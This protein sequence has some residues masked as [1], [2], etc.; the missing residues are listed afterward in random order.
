M[1][2][3]INWKEDEDAV[4]RYYCN[5]G[6]SAKAITDKLNAFIGGDDPRSE[7]AVR[8][9]LDR[10]GLKTLRAEKFK[11]SKITPE[12]R[13]FVYVNRH[14]TLEQIRELFNRFF[15]TSF[16][17]TFI[18]K[19]MLE[20]RATRE[21]VMTASDFALEWRDLQERIAPNG[22]VRRHH[23]LW[24]WKR[25]DDNRSAAGAVFRGKAAKVELSTRKYELPLYY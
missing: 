4:L 10:L 13:D 6:Y 15:E 1:P 17:M 16:P 7:S 23:W 25:F 19:V 9:R 2:K 18:Y 8:C 14:K 22:E 24:R 21:H 3:I 5:H 20:A 11:S 12:M